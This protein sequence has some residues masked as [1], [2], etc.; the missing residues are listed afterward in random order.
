[1][2][3]D[4]RKISDNGYFIYKIQHMQQVVHTV[5]RGA[6]NDVTELSSSPPTPAFIL[7]QKREEVLSEDSQDP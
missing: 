3:S 1:M 4:Q 7:H 6:R 2:K 5:L